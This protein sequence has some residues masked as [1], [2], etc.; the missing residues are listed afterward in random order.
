MKMTK[1]T[2]I[3]FAAIILVSVIIAVAVFARPMIV[4]K[5][6]GHVSPFIEPILMGH[7][8]ALNGNEYH[9]LDVNAVKTINVSHGFIHSLLSHKKSQGE[10][11]NEINDAK[12][13]A[14]IRAHLR[15]AGNAYTL[16]IT[17]Y[18]NQSLMGDVLT[19]PP[20]GT[21][22]ESF[23]SN[24]VGH[25][26]LST[27]GYEGESLITGTLTMNGT[28]YRVLMTSPMTLRKW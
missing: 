16:N 20:P 28:D 24:A 19:L 7:G 26:S 9:I 2:A 3:M 5:E 23:T 12:I 22:Q 10:I 8:F 14:S 25:I 27:L 13:A 6:R 4:G 15:F 17:A 21:N 18:D 1:K 11:E